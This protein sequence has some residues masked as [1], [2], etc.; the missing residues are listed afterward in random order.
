MNKAQSICGNI[1]SRLPEYVSGDLSRSER[2]EIDGHLATCI[3]C[4]KLFEE[5]G[6][7]IHEERPHHGHGHGR[8]ARGHSTSIQNAGLH[9]PVMLINSSRHLVILV[10]GAFVVVGL[11]LVLVISS[12]VT[13]VEQKQQGYIDLTTGN[14]LDARR[15]RLANRQKDR[16][17]TQAPMPVSNPLPPAAEPMSPPPSATTHTATPAPPMPAPAPAAQPPANPGIPP[18]YS[19]PAASTNPLYQPIAMA[20][21]EARINH[22][23]QQSALPPAPANPAVAPAA[24][25]NPAPNSYTPTAPTHP[26]TIPSPSEGVGGKVV[27][28]Y[29]F[30]NAF[31]YRY[32]EHKNDGLDIRIEY[33]PSPFN[34]GLHIVRIALVAPGSK[35]VNPDIAETIL[36]IPPVDDEMGLR[37]VSALLPRLTQAVGRAGRVSIISCGYRPQ[38]I[39]EDVPAS[40]ELVLRRSLSTRPLRDVAWD[41]ALTEAFGRGAGS[42]GRRVVLVVNSDDTSSMST[43]DRW[44]KPQ[45]N[46]QVVALPVGRNPSASPVAKRAAARYGAKVLHIT[47]GSVITLDQLR[48]AIETEGR[49]AA[50]SLMFTVT[51]NRQIVRRARPV[52]RG[53]DWITGSAHVPPMI[54]AI[55]EGQALTYLYEVEISRDLGEGE[56]LADCKAIYD[57]GVRKGEEVIRSCTTEFGRDELSRGS[58]GFQLAVMTSEALRQLPQSMKIKESDLRD[59]ADQIARLPRKARFEDIVRAFQQN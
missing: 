54:S 15:E 22:P 9:P 6:A 27:D 47:S 24:P 42:R 8:S 1:K 10:L 37:R 40:Q 7:V 36:C 33:A 3:D 38:V 50:S 51:F 44:P 30:V 5:I 20:Y 14:L 11:I 26:M 2:R 43:P 35:P 17:D 55:H 57:R 19:Q 53:A 52:T 49:V 39:A 31:D 56:R 18:V 13:G 45:E 21:P 46:V 41:T 16:Q 12:G 4:K 29:S 59:V 32:H 23:Q 48:S 58:L 34:P 25:V 28:D